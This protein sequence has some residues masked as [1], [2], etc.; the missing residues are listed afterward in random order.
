MPGLQKLHIQILCRHRGS[1]LVCGDG[2]VS[3]TDRTSVH[4][5]RCS[6]FWVNTSF[7]G[8]AEH[9]GSRLSPHAWKK[10]MNVWTCTRR[11]GW[12]TLAVGVWARIEREVASGLSGERNAMEVWWEKESWL[13]AGWETQSPL[14]TLYRHHRNSSPPGCNWIQMRELYHFLTKWLQDG[15][16]RYCPDF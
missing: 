14:I 11:C 4:F 1:R 2:N 8:Q 16:Q 13:V 3:G 9:S 7:S 12:R 10:C 5:Y 15:G 6:P